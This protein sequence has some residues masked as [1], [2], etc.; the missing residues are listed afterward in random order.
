M[1][2]YYAELLN[3][4]TNEKYMTYINTHEILNEG[5]EINIDGDITVIVR[6]Y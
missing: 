3:T 5:D 2:R 6:I 1:N 4:R